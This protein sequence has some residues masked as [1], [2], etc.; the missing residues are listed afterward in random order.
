MQEDDSV[1]DTISGKVVNAVC[2]CVLVS[3]AVDR[4]NNI[5][6]AVVKPGEARRSRLRLFLTGQRFLP[7]W[8]RLDL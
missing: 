5:G 3:N 8:L 7:G 2:A 6:L 4:E 1:C